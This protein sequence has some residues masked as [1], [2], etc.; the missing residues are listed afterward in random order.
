M[1]TRFGMSKE[2][3]M[4]ALGT[5]NSPYLNS[6]TSLTCSDGTAQ[7]V[8]EA[9]VKLVEEA[10]QQALQILRENKFKLHEL[11]AYLMRKESITGDEFMA[12]L[13]DNGGQGSPQLS[14]AAE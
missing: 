11:A 1:I 3:G 14:G 2:F 8:D 10:H 4:V 6:D 7:K 5:V 12:I 13:D 9:V